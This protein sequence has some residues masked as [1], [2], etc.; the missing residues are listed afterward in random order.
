MRVDS[1]S[2]SIQNSFNTT[3]F[4]EGVYFPFTTY[5]SCQCRYHY[6]DFLVESSV[7]I[8]SYI[9]QMLILLVSFTQV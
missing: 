9:G 4:P 6:N 2:E 5:V 8:K 3:A 7:G 1:F